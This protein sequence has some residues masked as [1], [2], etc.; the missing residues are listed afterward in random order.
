MKTK[1]EIP[2]FLVFLSCFVFSVSTFGQGRLLLVGGGSER[3][4][5]NSWNYQAFLWLTQNA[6][7]KKVAVISYESGGSTLVTNFTTIW[8]ASFAK[9]FVINSSNAN[10]Q[11]TYDSLIN[12]D[13]VYF[14]GGDQ[15]NYYNFYKGTKTQQALEYIYHNGGAIAGTSAGMHILTKVIFTAQNGSVYPDECIE[16]PT[17]PYI[18]LANDFLNFLPGVVGDT[19]FAERG[20]FARLLG[21]MANRKFLLNENVVGIGVDDQ[22]ALAIEAN[23]IATVYGAGCVNIYIASDNAFSRNPTPDG[24]LLANNVKVIQLKQGNIINLITLDVVSAPENSTQLIYEQEVAP[25]RLFLS[26]SDNLNNNTLMLSLF[27]SELSSPNDTILLLTGTTQTLANSYKTKLNELGATNVFVQSALNSNGSDSQLATL[28]T[29]AKGFVVVGNTYTQFNEFLSTNNGALLKNRLSQASTVT[30]FV[31]DNSRF[32]GA[33]VVE[34][35]MAAYASYDATMTFQPGLGLLRTTVIMPNTY[36]STNMYENAVTAVPYAMNQFGLSYGIWLYAQN[37]FKYY[38]QDG[39]TYGKGYGAAPV[40]ILHNTSTF[41]G[42]VTQ[43]P[44][45]N[46]PARQISAFNQMHIS[47]IDESTPYKMGDYVSTHVILE[48]PYTVYPNPVKN[49]I[50]FSGNNSMTVRIYN[51]QGIEVLSVFKFKDNTLDVSNLP[52]GIYM[53]MV[54]TDESTQI[55][56][57]IKN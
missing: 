34:N 52:R 41:W 28:I 38:N 55:G 20:R 8:G 57:F 36:A 29:R 26:G 42:H 24:K 15:K 37:F 17:N 23:K 7:Q 54:Q 5:T 25:Y 31:G 32:A 2:K 6:Q 12:Y 51:L 35:Y 14:R 45:G 50:Y 3:T 39:K 43:T 56:K 30:A 22:T 10:L 18:T 13:I 19:H 16:N 4:G 27:L 47:L 44:S 53:L 46:P 48:Q 11:A 33:I 1:F 21:F 40:M 9:E 49:E